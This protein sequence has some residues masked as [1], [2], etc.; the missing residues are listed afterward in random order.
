MLSQRVRPFSRLYSRPFHLVIAGGTGLLLGV[1]SLWLSPVLVLGALVAVFLA[2]AVLKRPEIALLGVLGATSSIVFEDRLPL[3]PIG[4]GSL[5]IPDVFL[6]ALLG[7]IVLRWLV[8]PDFKIVRTPFDWPL[9]AF[10]GLTLLSTVIAILR[11]S[12]GFNMAFRGV[13]VVTY[14]LTFFVVTNLVREG[15]QILLL[16]RGLFLLATVVAVAM[17]AQF[18]LGGAVSILPGRVETLTTQGVSYGGIARILPPGQS[19]V[20]GTFVVATVTLVLD[21]FRL[22]S[23][24][25]FIQ[26]CFLGLGL[27]LTFNR[28][29]W[30]AIAVALL[31]LMCLVRGQ[32]R[33]R[34]VGWGLVVALSAAI[35]LLPVLAEPGSRLARLASASMERLGTLAG[36]GKV[37][38]DSSFQWRYP[39]YEHALPQ[40]VSHP[41][42][43]LGLGA[44]YRSRDPRLDWEGFEGG[45]YIHNGH[46]WIMMK[47]GLL[48]YLSLMWLSL[49]FLLRGFKCWQLIPD[50][51][52]KGTVLGFTLTYLGMLLI[53]VVDPVLMTWS[54]TPVIGLMVGLNEAILRDSVFRKVT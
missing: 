54:W 47:S 13:R 19:I 22:V 1:A 42:L 17:I 51:R 44:R 7:L 10:Y 46:L 23:T 41:L 43:G 38:A 50:V 4:V 34:L 12:V 45:A 33:K 25:R 11:S 16:L 18:L 27:L 36:V 40:V 32:N 30:V 24:L 37:L 2:I 31:F 3:V 49:N 53:A 5:H 15:R 21:R 35:I 28:S 8:E 52:M 48:G 29:S 14:Y 39:E 26:W 20:L 6:L 9:L